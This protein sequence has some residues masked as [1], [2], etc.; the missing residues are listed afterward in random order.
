MQVNK[1]REC[2]ERGTCTYI[3]RTEILERGDGVSAPSL[4]PGDDLA[5]RHVF[6]ISE[7]G[8]VL[9]MKKMEAYLWLGKAKYLLEDIFAFYTSTLVRVFFRSPL[10]L[11]LSLS[12]LFIPLCLAGLGYLH[13]VLSLLLA[14]SRGKVHAPHVNSSGRSETRRRRA[15][16]NVQSSS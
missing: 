4:R 14:P 11:Y 8:S 10:F 16:R 2:G 15:Q 3:H 6:A 12:L 1:A 5:H 7:D 9:V 13:V